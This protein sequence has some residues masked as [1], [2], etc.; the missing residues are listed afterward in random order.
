MPEGRF[1]LRYR[2]AGQ[3]PER[4]VDRIRAVPGT[5]VVDQSARMLLVEGPADPLK[6]LV[7]T[8]PDWIMTAERMIRLPDARPKIRRGPGEA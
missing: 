4:D 1:I 5:A 2:G 8:L 3:A 6:A 7:D